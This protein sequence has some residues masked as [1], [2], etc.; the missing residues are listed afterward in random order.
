VWGCHT[1][2]VS[3]IT[4]SPNLSPKGGEEHEGSGAT[5]APTR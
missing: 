3:C 4:P 5:D 2:I 1:K